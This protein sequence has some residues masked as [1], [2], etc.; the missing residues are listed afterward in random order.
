MGATGATGAGPAGAVELYLPGAGSRPAALS[1]GFIREVEKHT[2]RMVSRCYQCK[3]C[4]SGCPAGFTLDF[5]CHEVIRLVQLGARADVLKSKAIWLCASCKTC[6]ERCP[7]DVD[8]A[9]VMDCLKVLAVASG[10]PLGR[11]RVKAFQKAFLQTVAM[12]GRAHELGSIVLYKMAT[13][14]SA[15]DDMGLGVKMLGRGKLKIAPDRIKGRGQVAAIFRK[16]RDKARK[17]ATE[18]K[19]GGGR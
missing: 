2:G 1:P 17:L 9:A 15:M 5:Q 18:S 13:P 10:V 16:A 12:F 4:T 7:N 19:G 6:R 11:K 3:K 14:A 8:P